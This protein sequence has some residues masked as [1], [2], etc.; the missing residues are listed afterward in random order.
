MQDI[1]SIGNSNY[2]AI[3]SI[4]IYIY[5]YN[6]NSFNLIYS[7]K[8]RIIPIRNKINNRIQSGNEFHFID[9]DKY[10]SVDINTLKTRVIYDNFDFKIDD[11]LECSIDGNIFY[12]IAGN[13]SLFKFNCDQQSVSVLFVK[14]V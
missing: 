7:N 14:P 5:D 8:K 11:I 4:G 2:L 6:L 10:L 9:D 1:F 13:K 3:S 12:G